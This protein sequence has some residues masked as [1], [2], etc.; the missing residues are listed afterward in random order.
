MLEIMFSRVCEHSINS[1][2]YIP[3]DKVQPTKVI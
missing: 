3:G 2:S 1:A